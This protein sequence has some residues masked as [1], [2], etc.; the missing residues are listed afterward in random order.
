[1]ANQ[2]KPTKAGVIRSGLARYP[3]LMPKE[4]AEKLNEELKSKKVPVTVRAEDISPYKSAA[5]AAQGKS[6]ATKAT[7]SDVTLDEVKFVH[8]L[9][10]RLG[11]DKVT[12]MVELFK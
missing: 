8:E 7:V 10:K 3:E 12:E 2:K 5:K 6:P 9:V 1:M 11:A 4:L